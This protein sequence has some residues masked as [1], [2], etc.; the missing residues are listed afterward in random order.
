MKNEIKN[1]RM[2]KIWPKSSRS[3][4][5]PR[6]STMSTSMRLKAAD[7]YVDVEGHEG[8][9]PQP[10]HH[11]EAP[12]DLATI[13]PKFALLRGRPYVEKMATLA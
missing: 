12:V 8:V 5:Q 1:K 11:A 13:E 7:V 2:T 3:T 9:D 6:M 10:G 4:K